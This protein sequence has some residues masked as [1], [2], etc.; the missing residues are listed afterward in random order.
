MLSPERL[1]VRFERFAADRAAGEPET[2]RFAAWLESHW[3]ND[4]APEPGEPPAAVSQL[5]AVGAIRWHNAAGAI[6]G[7]PI[8]RASGCY[9]VPQWATPPGLADC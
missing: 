1:A 5:G 7:Y 8:G 4:A 9:C 2:D 3:M 6:L